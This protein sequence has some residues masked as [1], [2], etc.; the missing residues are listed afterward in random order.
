LEEPVL[1][2]DVELPMQLAEFR[3]GRVHTH[4]NGVSGVRGSRKSNRDFV[5]EVDLEEEHS[6]ES[7]ESL[8]EVK[9]SLEF[10]VSVRSEGGP[11]DKETQVWLDDLGEFMDG[12]H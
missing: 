7:E 3:E 9:E 10:L 1:R 8:Q 12:M 6:Q 5:E 11:R 4:T 2:E